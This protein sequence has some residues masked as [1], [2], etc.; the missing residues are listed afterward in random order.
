MTPAQRFRRVLFWALTGGALARLYVL[1]EARGWSLV[2]PVALRIT[3]L[4]LAGWFVHLLLHEGGH[5]VAARFMRFQLDAVAL[6]PVEWSARDRAWSWAGLSLGG[7]ISTLPIGA[8]DLRRRLRIVAAAGP[9]VTL[10]AL[11]ALALAW[12][13]RA[14]PITSPLGIFLVA[15]ALVVVS[16]A[17]PGRFRQAT[18]VAGNDVDQMLGGRRIVAHWTYLAVV[19]AVLA[20]RRPREVT[21]GLDF[22]A[23]LPPAGAAPEPISLI[24]AV[25]HLERGEFAEAKALLQPASQVV[26]DAPGWVHTDVFHQLGAIAALVDGDSDEAVRCLEVVRK[27]QSLPWYG[28]LLEA[29]IAKAGGDAEMADK[30]LARWL[31]EAK[32]ASGGRLAF[33]GNEW[34]LERL[35]AAWRAR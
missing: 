28:D 27:K 9:L 3:G 1:G 7:R 12:A 18:A 10:V 21:A 2:G 30:R 33:G 20:G 8:H 6:G 11:A 23:L 25:H 5:L 32:A 16:A 24:N 35:D 19:Q 17:T 14:E 22:P 15:G 29:C 13:L 31:A 34:I 26:E 4:T